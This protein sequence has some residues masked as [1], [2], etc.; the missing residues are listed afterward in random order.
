MHINLV[1]KNQTDTSQIIH[2]T[3]LKYIK[4]SV[5]SVFIDVFSELQS[6]LKFNYH[7]SCQIILIYVLYILKNLFF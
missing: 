7:Q 6:H 2:V 1:F 4:I 3:L 5:W